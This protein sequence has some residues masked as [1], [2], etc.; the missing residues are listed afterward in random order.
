VTAAKP[1]PDLFLAAARSLSL[2][3]EKCVVFE[4]AADGVIAAHRAGMRVVGIGPAERVGDADMVL[5]G[6]AAADLDL[7]LAIREAPART[8][9]G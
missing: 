6:L 2:D 5:S 4:D 9:A 7:I 3:P 1:A 8:H